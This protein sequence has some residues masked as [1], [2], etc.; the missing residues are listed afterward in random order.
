MLLQL[1]YLIV[2]LTGLPDNRYKVTKNTKIATLNEIV[3]VLTKCMYYEHLN[4][5][6]KKKKQ[7]TIR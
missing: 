1:E 2:C 7:I 5:H 4:I 6:E 3:L